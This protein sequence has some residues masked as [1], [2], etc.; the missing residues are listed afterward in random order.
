MS[1]D[2]SDPS[3]DCHQEVVSVSV[4][5]S[6]EEREPLAPILLYLGRGVDAI[7]HCFCCSIVSFGLEFLKFLF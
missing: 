6:T 1:R 2:M 7:F 3:C 4:H 5:I